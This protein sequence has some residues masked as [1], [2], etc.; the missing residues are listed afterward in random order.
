MNDALTLTVNEPWA[1]RL[2][3]QHNRVQ[4]E[5]VQVWEAPQILSWERYARESWLKSWP[6]EMLLS[7]IQELCLWEDC[8]QEL[9]PQTGLLDVRQLARLLMQARQTAMR[10]E[11][12]WQQG[13]HWSSEQKLFNSVS[14]RFEECL[15]ARGWIS[16]ADLP[17]QCLLA[18]SSGRL[19]VPDRLVAEGFHLPHPPIAR[20]FLQDLSSLG[21]DIAHNDVT[22]GSG[23]IQ[24]WLCPD[25]GAQ[26]LAIAAQ[27][28]QLLQAAPEARIVVAVPRFSEPLRRQIDVLWRE[29]LDPA[30]LRQPR[31]SAGALWGYEHSLSLAEQPAIA[32]ALM[33]V[34]LQPYDNPRSIVSALLLNP[35]LFAPDERLSCA[36]LENA[37]RRQGPRC[38]LKRLRHALDRLTPDSL[39]H[40]LLRYLDVV[41]STPRQASCETWLAHWQ[42]CW[43]ALDYATS[44]QGWPLGEEFDQALLQFSA[45]DEQRPQLN[46]TQALSCLREVLQTQRYEA[47]ETQSAPIRICDL[48]T[49]LA[50]EADHYVLADMCNRHFPLATRIDPFLNLD[51]QLACGWPAASPEASLQQ[52]RTLLQAFQSCGKPLHIFC[53]TTNDL[54]AEQHP[55]PLLEL[56]WQH[57]TAT[58]EAR[59]HSAAQPRTHDPVPALDHTRQQNQTGAIRV[60]QAQAHGPFFA[61]ARH[62]LGLTALEETRE[63]LSPMAQGEWIHA[64]LQQ[65]WETHRSQHRLLGLDESALTEDLYPRIQALAERHAPL[66]QFGPYLQQAE[67]DRILRCCRDWLLHEQRRKDPFEVLHCELGLEERLRAFDFQ[68]RIDRIDRCDTPRGPRYLLIDYKTSRSLDEKYWQV[69]QFYEPQLPLYAC[70]QSLRELGIPTVDGICFAQVQEQFPAFVAS[71]NWRKRLIADDKRE[72]HMDWDAQLSAWR[73]RLNELIDGY[74]S[75]G[76]E[77]DLNT[78]YRRRHVVADLLELIDIASLDSAEDNGEDSDEQRA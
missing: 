9:Q 30:W 55:S 14:H 63:G 47:S 43:L 65:F 37:L 77:I 11:M 36:E 34:Q 13:P 22:G 73:Q 31:P 10:W 60:V 53:A 51:Q 71:L 40:R 78:D 61:F 39:R 59:D 56:E 69:Q 41:E 19:A 50:L 7:P 58:L 15:Q 33:A 68:L 6:P 45:L 48:E 24:A 20:R 26:W 18:F 27:L 32:A 66:A 8:L 17:Q 42:R 76:S 62:R 64:V 44:G 72:F 67:C 23:E 2:R 28:R 16:A 75:G 5:R 70:S 3:R 4:R 21:C 52:A 74:C 1:R 25:E 49:A 57:T 38:S 54:G 29:Q 46:Q 12:P 35:R